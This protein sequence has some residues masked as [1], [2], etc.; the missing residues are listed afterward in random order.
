[1]VKSLLWYGPHRML[2]FERHLP[3]AR[4]A[5]SFPAENQRRASGEKADSF[6]FLESDR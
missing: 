6:T 3:D 1:L 4:P 5:P 2:E